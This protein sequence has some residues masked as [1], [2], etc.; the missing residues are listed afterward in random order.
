MPK[1]QIDSQWNPIGKVPRGKAIVV[2]TVMGIECLAYVPKR[3]KIRFPDDRV[4][5]KRINARRLQPGTLVERGDV[6]AVAWKPFSSE[7]I[8]GI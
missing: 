8:P 7:W 5:I 6:R 1:A 2:K 3:S 4:K